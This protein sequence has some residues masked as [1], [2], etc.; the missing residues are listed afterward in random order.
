MLSFYKELLT[1]PDF[2]TLNYN[3]FIFMKMDFPNIITMFI[4]VYNIYFQ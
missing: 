2:V 1:R 3:F 4:Y